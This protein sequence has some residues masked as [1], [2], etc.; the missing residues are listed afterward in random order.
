[1]DD[2]ETGAAMNKEEQSQIAAMNKEQQ[3]QM[4]EALEKIGQGMKD[5]EGGTCC[6]C[7]T[8]GTVQGVW[9]PKDGE[10]ELWG[11]KADKVRLFLYNLCDTCQLLPDYQKKLEAEFARRTA[12][13]MIEVD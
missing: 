4:D 2:V 5:L 7:K 3:S 10:E 12:P 6:L 8:L 13:T 11:G 1:M 9:S